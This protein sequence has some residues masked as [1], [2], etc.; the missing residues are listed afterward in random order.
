[1][2]L[3]ITAP[4]VVLVQRGQDVTKAFAIV[5]SSN[6]PSTGELLVAQAPPTTEGSAATSE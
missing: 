4:L 1:M 3:R 2:Q 5:I 6:Q